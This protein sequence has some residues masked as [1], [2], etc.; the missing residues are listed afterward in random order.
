MAQGEESPDS[1]GAMNELAVLRALAKNDLFSGVRSQADLDAIFAKAF[2]A[3]PKPY[4]LML[5]RLLG[6]H[7]HNVEKQARAF[8][9]EILAHR[10]LLAD[11]LG[12][13]VH[14][15]VAALDLIALGRAPEGFGWPIL[16]GPRV[17]K[18]FLASLDRREA[19]KSRA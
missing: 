3:V 15:R 19:R 11:K 7:P 6:Y 9:V 5:C 1:D 17:L 8:W 4:A 18:R 13:P 2:A 12:R 16:V 10:E 14:L